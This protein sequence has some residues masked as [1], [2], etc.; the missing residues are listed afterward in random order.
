MARGFTPSQMG[1][2]STHKDF[3]RPKHRNF[4]ATVKK[5]L[6]FVLEKYKNGST[7]TRQTT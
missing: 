2:N 1:A 6:E 3:C 4:N 5:A 7:I